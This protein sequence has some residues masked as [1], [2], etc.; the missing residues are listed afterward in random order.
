MQLNL[1]VLGTECSRALFLFCLHLGLLVFR[2]HT[3]SKHSGCY[4]YVPC[5]NMKHR[6]ASHLSPN[7][8]QSH[9]PPLF[10]GSPEAAVSE[11][12]ETQQNLVPFPEVIRLRQ[13]CQSSCGGKLFWG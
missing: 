10:S 9:M 2:V 5:G 4:I 11:I 7:Q 12:A 8:M 13:V 3:G 6:Q 1:N